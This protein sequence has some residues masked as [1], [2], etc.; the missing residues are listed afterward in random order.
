MSKNKLIATTIAVFIVTLG[1]LFISSFTSSKTNQPGEKIEDLGRE[2]VSNISDVVYNSNPPTSGSH[3]PVWA[4]NGAYDRVLSDGYLIH[5]LEHGY[6]VI[7]Y[8]CDKEAVSFQPSVIRQVQAHEGEPVEI[9]DIATSSAKPLMQ[10]KLASKDTDSFTPDNPPDK[11]IELSE[12]FQLESC[13]QLV[14]DLSG[15]LN[16]FS[17]LIVVPRPNLDSRIAITAWGKLEK[18][19]SFDKV[20]I[21]KFI[22]AYH[23]KG[24]EK[25]ME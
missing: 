10:M 25:T 24:P 9:H 15:L 3:F 19:D 20:K 6:I 23:N 4:K 7:S 5:S 21:T 2:H 1:W 11:E 16:D 8:N 14:K 22:K 17:R 18:L 12:N 13:N